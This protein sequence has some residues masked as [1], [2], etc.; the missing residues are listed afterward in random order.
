MNWNLFVKNFSPTQSDF[1]AKLLCLFLF[2]FKLECVARASSQTISLHLIEVIMLKYT[3]KCVC[4]YIHAWLSDPLRCWNCSMFILCLAFFMLI[5]LFAYFLFVRPAEQ[6]LILFDHMRASRFSLEF[7]K[8]FFTFHPHHYQHWWLFRLH[9]TTR[10]NERQCVCV[11]ER[12][13]SALLFLKSFEMKRFSQ[14]F[15]WLAIDPSVNSRPAILNYQ[16]SA[17][18]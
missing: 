18:E 8:Q 6:L 15:K 17:I 2:I 11:W 9:N 16:H 13:D 12:T 5:F 14:P 3:H 10:L 4:V 7:D 1:V